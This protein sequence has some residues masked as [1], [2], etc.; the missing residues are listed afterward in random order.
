MAEN[1]EY[2]AAFEEE[3][4]ILAKE[5]EQRQKL[6]SLVSS[7]RRSQH[8]SQQQLAKRMN[9]SQARISQME[10][11]REPLSVDSLLQMVESLS[12]C[13]TIL[14]PEEIQQY[15]LEHRLVTNGEAIRKVLV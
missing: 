9:V 12:G 7:I 6:M 1:P 5:L 4:A 8:M 15:G 13:I 3:E 11:G 14:T 2:R 10:R